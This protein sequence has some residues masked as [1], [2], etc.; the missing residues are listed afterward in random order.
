MQALIEFYTSCL[1]AMARAASVDPSY[2]QLVL[3]LETFG[4]HLMHF[5]AKHVSQCSNSLSVDIM[6]MDYSE[7]RANSNP[8]RSHTSK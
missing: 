4:T 2:N 1:P 3:S 5:S 6:S 8:P 7:T